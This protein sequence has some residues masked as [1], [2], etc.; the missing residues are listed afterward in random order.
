MTPRVLPFGEAALLL[1]LGD[2]FDESVAGWARVIA[3]LWELGPAIPA[4]ASVMVSFD[5][6][7][8]DPEIAD[9]HARNLLAETASAADDRDLATLQVERRRR[10]GFPRERLVGNAGHRHGALLDAAA[11]E[12]RVGAVVSMTIAFWPPRLEAPPT[13]GSV[14]VALLVAVSLIV[15]PFSVSDVVAE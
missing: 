4:Y 10:D 9:R 12:T 11:I 5:P 7:V 13:V 15:P 1:E 6:A 3:D 8:I 14:R 2:V